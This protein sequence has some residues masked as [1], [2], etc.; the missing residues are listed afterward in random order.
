MVMSTLLLHTTLSSLIWQD[1]QPRR[2]LKFNFII[3]R[4]EA[5]IMSLGCDLGTRQDKV[6]LILACSFE[7]H[8]GFGG[9]REVHDS[10]H[11]LLTKRDSILI[12]CVHRGH[13][14]SRVKWYQQIYNLLKL[15]A[16]LLVGSDYP[17]SISTNP[18]Y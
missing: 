7:P 6:S 15:V 17:K 3:K 5:T 18:V 14:I 8:W 1:I 9:E 2:H 12:Q 11:K 16:F 4:Y 10:K 13:A